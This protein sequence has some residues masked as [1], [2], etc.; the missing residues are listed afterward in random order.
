MFEVNLYTFVLPPLDQS[1]SNPP[2]AGSYV[3]FG[4]GKCLLGIGDE[5]GNVF[6]ESSH[7]ANGMSCRSTDLSRKVIHKEG[8]VMV[9]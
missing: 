5:L 7:L 9:G 6:D 8:G 2:A 4:G 3:G 1:I